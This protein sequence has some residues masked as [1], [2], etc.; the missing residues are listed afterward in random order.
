[1][2]LINSSV[3]LRECPTG[4]LKQSFAF[5]YFI[6][7]IFLFFL[8]AFAVFA[9]FVVII[10]VGG[11]IWPWWVRELTAGGSSADYCSGLAL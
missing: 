8:T 5:F 7:F 4:Q 3:T 9:V 6:Y 10:S 1:M 2:A 11:A